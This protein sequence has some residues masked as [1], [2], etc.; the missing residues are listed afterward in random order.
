MFACIYVY[1]NTYVYIF[2][3]RLAAH[4][5]VDTLGDERSEGLN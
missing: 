3:V 1:M 4:G 2:P 5:N